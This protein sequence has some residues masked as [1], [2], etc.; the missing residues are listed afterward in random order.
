M[1]EKL[2]NLAQV[3]GGKRLPKGQAFAE[4]KTEFPYIRVTNFHSRTVD[5]SDLK[6]ITKTTHDHIKRYVISQNDVYISIAGT[7]GIVGKVPPDLDGANLTENAAKIVINDTAVVNQDYLLW[8]LSTRGQRQIASKKKIAVQAKLA[9]YRIEEIEVPLPALEEQKRI[10]SILD[11]ADNLRRKRQQAIQ[12]ADEFLRAVFLDM[13]GDPVMNPKGWEK[14]AFATLL[15]AI[16][17]GA[18]PKCESRPAKK[19]EW[20]V[21]KLGAVSYCVYRP[22]ENKAMFEDSVPDVRHEVQQG[23]LLF[24]RKNTYELVAAS[25]IVEETPERL[26]LPDLIFRFQTNSR[27]NK[28]YLW[29]LL[30]HSGMRRSIQSLASGAAGS[31][32][33]ISKANLRSVSLCL[34]PISEQEKFE[35]ICRNIWDT[36]K[37]ILEVMNIPLFESLSQKAFSGEL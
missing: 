17:S 10:V 1:I 37:K 35:I 15:D 11:K 16:E 4:G 22:G 30:T 34:P 27:V 21:L 29:A 36:K 9:L 31:M 25:A 20:G 18:S 2:G 23:D 24:T 33:N 12:L 8:Y 7:I 28:F 14:V 5:K 13:F 3:K 19:R 26:L 6:Y 32:P